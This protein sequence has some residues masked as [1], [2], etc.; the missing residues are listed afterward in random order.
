MRLTDG[1]QMAGRTMTLTGKLD[2]NLTSNRYNS[3]AARLLLAR[4][5]KPVDLESMPSGDVLMFPADF[6]LDALDFR[7]EE[8]HRSAALC[9]H[10]VMVI[11][12]IVLMLVAGNA[13]VE[14]NLAGQTAFGQQL[15]RAVY[16]GEA[17]A[18]VLLLYQP[19]EFVGGEV[20]A[21]IEEGAED[22]SALARLFQ[23]YPA[24]VVVKNRLRLQ[25]H[26]A[27]DHRLII[28]TLL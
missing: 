14:R 23:S 6:A 4:I 15:E 28:D 24:Q 20:I 17:D 21:G 3:H 13:V 27:R 5:A 9:A 8:L 1:G 10:H 19:I 25:H 16:R 2:R 12:A 22:G 11:A 7:R 18:F 26:L